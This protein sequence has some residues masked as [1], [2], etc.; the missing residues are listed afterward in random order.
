VNKLTEKI[1]QNQNLHLEDVGQL[2]RPPRWLGRPFQ[3]TYPQVQPQFPIAR[4][5]ESLHGLQR[6]FGNSWVISWETSRNRPE[7]LTIKRNRR[8]WLSRARTR[9]TRKT[10]KSS[11]IQGR[12]WGQSHQPKRH[13]V[14]IRDTQQKTQKIILKTPPRKSQQRAQKI[15]TK[16]DRKS[17]T[18]PWGTTPSYLDIPWRFIQG[19]ACHP[20]I[21]PSL[22][23]S[24]DA[25]KLVLGKTREK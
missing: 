12:F 14:L 8:F 25:L 24:H 21:H 15:T 22:K 6:N 13:K 9:A 20:Y 7:S 2:D 5:P 3:K 10:T 11:P 16:K 23:I 17:N 18:Q 4:S 19:L 1:R